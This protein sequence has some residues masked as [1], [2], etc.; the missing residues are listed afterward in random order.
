LKQL[1]QSP[2]ILIILLAVVIRIPDMISVQ[3]MT[4]ESVEIM[5]IAGNLRAGHGFLIDIKST[6]AI[7]EPV[8][9]YA[10]F[11]RPVFLPAMLALM[12]TVMPDRLAVGLTGT[13]LFA[14]GLFFVFRVLNK[15]TG[16]NTATFTCLLLAS[17]PYFYRLTAIPA[18]ET[19]LVM[20]IGAILWS[21]VCAQSVFL[22]GLSCLAAVFIHPLGIIPA[23]VISI[24]N[25]RTGIR[26]REWMPLMIHACLMVLCLI[27]I[28]VLNRFYGAPWFTYPG[29]YLF[30]VMDATD[31]SLNFYRHPPY[32][33]IFSLLA[34]NPALIPQRWWLNLKSLGIQMFG[35]QGI[36]FL[37]PL[38][39][40]AWFGL[41]RNSRLNRLLPLGGIAAGMVMVHCLAWSNPH[42][43]PASGTLIFMLVILVIT[44]SF[45]ILDR[46]PVI[47]G[48]GT[49]YS[50]GNYI[51]LAI[52][53]CWV[54][55]CVNP[56]LETTS[57]TPFSSRHIYSD[58]GLKDEYSID[59]HGLSSNST[60]SGMESVVVGNNPWLAWHL[61]GMPSAMLPGDLMTKDAIRL[62]DSLGSSTILIDTDQKTTDMTP[63]QDSLFLHLENQGWQTLGVG[64]RIKIWIRGAGP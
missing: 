48:D 7:D 63:S 43:F 5:N 28:I 42:F 59:P 14:F 3:P 23:L 45:E 27:W 41:R 15:L 1:Q 34:D 12:Q 46:E 38:I 60:V 32:D 18:D 51:C 11:N 50:A 30:H 62:V 58:T 21:Q 64:Q 22:T 49:G 54:V 47:R 57:T 33:D 17:H 4:A 6:Y 31:K 55:L 10:F 19:A 2:F 20:I 25:L 24:Q 29:K 8:T 56:G 35:L 44:G 40:V 37:I 52:L 53:I 26:H 39:P 16:R 36:A 13:V 9:H 61:T